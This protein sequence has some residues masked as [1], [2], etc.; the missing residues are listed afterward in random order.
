[1]RSQTLR[2]ALLV[3]LALLIPIAWLAMK[4]SPYAIDGDGMAYMDIADLMR[5]HH[6]AGVI[7]AYWNPLYPAGLAL[8]QRLFHTTRMNELHAYYVLNYV[9][10]L[11]SVAAML[12]FVSALVTLRRRM[13]PNADQN[14]GASPLLGID[15]LRLLGVAL[16]VIAA[17]RELSMAAIR[18]DALLQ[19]LMLAAFA[20]L[21]QSFVSESL[22][23]PPMMGFFLGLAY[24]SKSFAFVVAVL[25]IAAMMIFQSWVQRRKPVRV[26]A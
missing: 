6:W 23:Y 24:L 20:M 4:F 11:G 1:M 15:A 26:I 16:V 10:F 19:A 8:A 2:R 5:S 22:M 17:Q 21:L 9:I 3:Y 25:T 13:T 14:A 18:P 12:L 7:N